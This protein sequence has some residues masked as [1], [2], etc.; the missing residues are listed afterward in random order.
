MDSL[1]WAAVSV[2]AMVIASVSYNRLEELRLQGVRQ[3]GDVEFM[4][5]E[6]RAAGLVEIRKAAAVR[7]DSLN[8]AGSKS[9]GIILATLHDGHAAGCGYC[10]CGHSKA[11]SALGEAHAVGQK[12]HAELEIRLLS[13]GWTPPGGAS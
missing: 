10:S 12:R 1:I 5:E 7:A 6:A 13:E 8:D 4:K 11:V 2:F 9:L 3:Q